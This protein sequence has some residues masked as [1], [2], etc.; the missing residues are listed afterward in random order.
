MKTV[1]IDDLHQYSVGDRRVPG[2]SQILEATGFIQPSPFWTDEA[3]DKGT[4]LHEACYEINTGTFDFNDSSSDIYF[5][6]LAYA[7]WKETTKFSVLL[8]ETRLYSEVHGFAGTLDAFGEFQDGSYALID[9]KRGYAMA[10][11]KY[12][13]AAYVMLLCENSQE[14]LG[15]KVYP[16]QVKRYAL[17][18]IGKER[19]HMKEYYDKSDLTIAVAAVACYNAQLRDGIIRMVGA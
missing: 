15:K 16:F 6:A 10:S 3:R 9:Y 14:L 11:A 7:E 5:E 8:A 18:R 1:A 17:E 12:Q 19:P 4:R 13:T 2:V